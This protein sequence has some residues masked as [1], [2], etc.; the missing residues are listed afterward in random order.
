MESLV[1]LALLLLGRGLTAEATAML[2]QADSL[3]PGE[4]RIRFYLGVTRMPAGDSGGARAMLEGIA[5]GADKYA[6]R[7]EQALAEVA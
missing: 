3:Q 1:D 7:A 6:M 5:A 4:S 2:E